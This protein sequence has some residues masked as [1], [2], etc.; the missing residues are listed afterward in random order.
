MTKAKPQERAREVRLLSLLLAALLWLSVA[1]ERSGELKLLVPVR[2]ESVPVGLC[3]ASPP[4]GRLE[5]TV[6]GPRILLFRLQLGGLDCGLDLAGREAGTAS[7]TPRESS[8]GLGR[9]LKLVR[10]SPSSVSLTL[11]KEAAK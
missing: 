7:F 5:V 9:E 1:L 8:F 3:L 11:A 6:T 4:P 2:P 10:V